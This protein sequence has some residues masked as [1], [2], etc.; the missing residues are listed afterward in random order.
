[1]SEQS[2]L[3][4]LC[5]HCFEPMQGIHSY[6][7]FTGRTVCVDCS[8]ELVETPETYTA[9]YTP[10]FLDHASNQDF[11]NGTPPRGAA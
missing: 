10:I 4:A 1:M 6:Q 3:W 7:N 9:K 11:P 5:T 2:T 8:G